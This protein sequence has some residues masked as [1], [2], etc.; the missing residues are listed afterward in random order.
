VTL[1]SLQ[2]ISQLFSLFYLS[3]G[4]E[5]IL[6]FVSDRC[7]III[8]FIS[9]ITYDIQEKNK[10]LRLAFFGIATLENILRGA[11]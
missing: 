3:H 1:A 6:R 5:E 11:H 8:F 4:L 2:I 7:V 10:D 9:Y